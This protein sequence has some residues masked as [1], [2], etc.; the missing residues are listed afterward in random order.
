MAN[1]HSRGF[2]KRG[3]LFLGQRSDAAFAAV[4]MAQRWYTT[5]DL[6]Y[7]RGVYPFVRDVALFWEDYLKFEA[8]PPAMIAAT[9]DLPEGLRQ[10][11]EGRFVIHNDGAFEGGRIRTRQCRS[12]WCGLF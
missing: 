2:G 3:G 4:N 11:A 12:A 5:Y 8:T 9:K 7:A 1:R 6:A 10:P